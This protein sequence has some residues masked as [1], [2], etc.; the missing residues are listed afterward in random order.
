MFGEN[1]GE[2]LLANRFLHA[3]AIKDFK[4]SKPVPKKN[5]IVQDENSRATTN[6]SSSTGKNPARIKSTTVRKAKPA[7][8]KK[9]GAKTKAVKS[10]KPIPAIEVSDEEVRIRAYF[11]AERRLSLGLPGDSNTD[12]LE[13]KRQLLSEIGPR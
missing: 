10:T 12:W 3:N 5:K 1:A 7:A 4:S 8:R 9:A 11:V 2:N 13:A 6:G